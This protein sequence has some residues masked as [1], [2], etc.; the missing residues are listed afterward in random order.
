MPA[1]KGFIRRGMFPE[2][3]FQQVPHRLLGPGVRWKPLAF[4]ELDHHL[5]IN[6]LRQFLVRHVRRAT[7][8]S[9]LTKA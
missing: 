1:R 6:L 2:A 8:L 9:Y 7:N 4:R 5:V 3:P